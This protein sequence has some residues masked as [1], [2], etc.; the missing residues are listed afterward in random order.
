MN[1]DVRKIEDSSGRADPLGPLVLP[2]GQ[3]FGQTH[4]PPGSGARQSQVRLGPDLVALNQGELAAWAGA[5][6]DPNEPGRPVSRDALESLLIRA[7]IPSPLL[8]VA[9]LLECGVLA[10][11][12]DTADARREFA[13]GHRFVPL[14]L[15]LGN[16]ATEP[17]YYAVGTMGN[18]MV[19]LTSQLYDIW[20]WAHL[21]PNL[22]VAL[23]GATATARGVG[24]TDPAQ[25]EPDLLLSDLLSATHS[26]LAVHAGYF[27]R[28]LAR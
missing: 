12:A 24:I 13:L 2:V 3:F 16:T 9:G 17:W 23:R 15:G 8:T 5:H 28:G 10:E 6:G 26:L 27:D 25:T 1:T 11:V 4:G 22:W 7:G 14:L 21:D 19:K 20:Q 18:P